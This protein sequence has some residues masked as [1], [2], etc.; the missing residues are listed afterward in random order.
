MAA[1]FADK[2]H[3]D[4]DVVLALPTDLVDAAYASLKTPEPADRAPLGD[5]APN[6]GGNAEDGELRKSTRTR[7]V[8]KKAVK[9]G[10]VDLAGSIAEEDDTSETGTGQ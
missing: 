7:K 4:E 10:K 1:D 3:V 6:R 2:L 8:G 5:I 9:D